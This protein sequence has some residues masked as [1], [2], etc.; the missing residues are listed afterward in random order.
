MA[1]P[2]SRD[3]LLAAAIEC[4]RTKGYAGTTARD[5]AGAA[6]ANLASIG[7]HFGSK[8]KL[9][10]EAVVRICEE[11]TDRMREA[12]AGQEGVSPLER[13]ARS[14]V[15]MLNE[16]ARDRALLAAFFSAAGQIEWSP[17]LRDRLAAQYRATREAVAEM[18]RD[19]LGPEAEG[20]DPLVVA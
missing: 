5:I 9:L 20:V 7:Y 13:I 12:A 19:S 11:W 4:L 1:P 3:Q 15:A 2:S 8:E 16:F 18:V 6:D 10:N 14:W 17:E